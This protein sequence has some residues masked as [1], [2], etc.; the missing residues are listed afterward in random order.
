M[1]CHMCPRHCRIDR[2]TALGVCG[3]PDGFLVSRVAPH[4][5]EEPCISGIWGSGTVFFGGCNLHCVY[6]QNAAISHGGVG[7]LM[8]GET[9][10]KRILALQ[11]MGVHNINLVTPT[12]YTL[13]LTRLLEKLKPKLT[14]PVVWNSSSYESVDSLKALDGLIDIYLPDFKYADAA[15][16]AKY[17]NAPDYPEIA[18]SAIKEMFRQCGRVQFDRDGLL[19][20]GM[21]VR[22]LVLP[23]HRQNSIDALS[24]LAKELPIKDI[25]LSLMSQYTPDFA[26]KER[27]PQ[28]ARR[29]TSFEYGRVLEHAMAL[30]FE[31]YLQDRQSAKKSYTP[32]F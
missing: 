27:F 24:I 26:D 21:L 25:R 5:F 31:G 28:L 7:E 18:V 29:V 10:E 9:L 22:H 30:G 15:L 14:V 19:K 3:A 17:S 11:D 12:H 2:R 6:C 23:S 1:T 4:S 13:L 8:D 16:A 20:T 32:D